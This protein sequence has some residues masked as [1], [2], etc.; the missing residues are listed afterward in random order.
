MAK[1]FNEYYLGWDEINSIIAAAK[2]LKESL[3]LK[4]LARTGMRRFELANLKAKDVD[5]ERKR[6]FIAKGKGANEKDPKSRSVPIDDDTIQVIKFYL[7]GRKTGFLIQSN[8]KTSDGISLSQINRIVANAAKR[9]HVNNP[10]PNLK[11]LNPHIFRHSF[12]RLSLAAGIPFNM[13]QRIAG[14]ADARTTLQMYG[15]PSI[16]DTQELYEEKLIEKFKQKPK[17]KNN[18]KLT[19]FTEKS[20]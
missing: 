5:F 4:L 10:N 9:A 14:H 7:E 6:L 20:K 18:T 15:I 1:K 2:N 17:S 3:V 11:N 16:T 12:S 8:K 13:V 19:K